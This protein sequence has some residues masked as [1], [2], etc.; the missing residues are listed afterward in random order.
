MPNGGVI[1]FLFFNLSDARPHVFI[2]GITEGSVA[3]E[4][5]RLRIGHRITA[6]KFKI[7]S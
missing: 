3:A 7:I 2:S 6:V 1:F 4:C 5:R